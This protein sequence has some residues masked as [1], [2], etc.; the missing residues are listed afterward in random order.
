MNRH[1]DNIDIFF[2]VFISIYFIFL[3]LFVTYYA[4][5]QLELVFNKNNLHLFKPISKQK[6]KPT[7]YKLNLKKR[8]IPY[9]VNI[10]YVNN[11]PKNK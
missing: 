4:L 5:C 10:S 11:T 2:I 6:I 9:Q 7:P 3:F 1:F 8:N